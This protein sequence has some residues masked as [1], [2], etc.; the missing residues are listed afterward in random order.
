[1]KNTNKILI[2]AA[3]SL[4]FASGAGDT[5]SNFSEL[6][7]NL[8]YYETQN[9][10]HIEQESQDKMLQIKEE[11]HARIRDIIRVQLEERMAQTGSTNISP[12]EQEQLLDRIMAEKVENNNIILSAIA[13]NNRIVVDLVNK[14]F[15]QYIVN[16][17][18]NIF[19][20]Q[21]TEESDYNKFISYEDEKA[22]LLGPGEERAVF[23]VPLD[24]TNTV[25]IPLKIFGQF[26]EECD[27]QFESAYQTPSSNSDIKVFKYRNNRLNWYRLNNVD[28]GS[29]NCATLYGTRDTGIAKCTLLNSHGNTYKEKILIPGMAYV[30]TPFVQEDYLVDNGDGTFTT[31]QRTAP[32]NPINIEA[33]PNAGGAANGNSQ[34]YSP[35]GTTGGTCYHYFDYIKY[36][37]EYEINLLSGD[38][39]IRIK[40]N[41]N[42]FAEEVQEF[43]MPTKLFMGTYGP[44][45]TTSTQNLGTAAGYGGGNILIGATQYPYSSMLNDGSGTI[46]FYAPDG[47][48]TYELNSVSQEVIK[49]ST[50]TE[51]NVQQVVHSSTAST[52]PWYEDKFST[53]YDLKDLEAKI[54]EIANMEGNILQHTTQPNPYTIADPNSTINCQTS[55]FK[56]KLDIPKLVT[57]L[58]AESYYKIVE[59]EPLTNGVCGVGYTLD[60]A[61]MRCVKDACNNGFVDDGNGKC[62]KGPTDSEFRQEKIYE[63]LTFTSN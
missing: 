1:M 49:V 40:E 57:N 36:V 63:Y 32:G 2:M 9:A 6:I 34:N 55:V 8:F 21:T 38:F 58:L 30:Y 15:D 5:K 7:E 28:D 18:K 42:P 52:K 26:V 17:K 54:T 62:L 23:I 27:I 10:K 39:R 59:N 19:V 16:N 33:C 4:S 51:Q 60:V 31:N 25:N 44:S 11:N 24:L 29:E 43:L 50:T 48:T 61:A 14:Y 13:N 56:F 22:P 45:E 41:K 3:L 20:G 47:T 35:G 37:V 53:V 46:Y 12:L